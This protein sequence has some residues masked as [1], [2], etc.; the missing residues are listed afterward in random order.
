MSETLARYPYITERLEKAAIK[1]GLKPFWI[2][3][4]GGTDGSKLTALGLPTPNIF[5]AACN[6][7]SLTE[8]QSIDGL[9]KVT[10]TLIHLVAV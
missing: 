1:A 2:P 5:T 9:V 4:R 6:A 3:I 7:H 8:W 10:D